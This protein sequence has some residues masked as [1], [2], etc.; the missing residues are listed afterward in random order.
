MGIEYNKEYTLFRNGERISNDD[1]LISDNIFNDYEVQMNFNFNISTRAIEE[2]E[3]QSKMLLEKLVKLT[4]NEISFD[5]GMTVY[6]MN[7]GDENTFDVKKVNWK[8]KERSDMFF[9]DDDENPF[10]GEMTLFRKTKFNKF[11]I[12]RII[13]KLPQN[14]VL[15]SF[16]EQD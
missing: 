3:N 12:S 5:E 8:S 2:T 13:C 9:I 1:A 6:K 7:A 16:G 10:N 4:G 11:E 15:Q 14:K